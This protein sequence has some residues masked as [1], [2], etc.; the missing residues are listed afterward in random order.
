M[1]WAVRSYLPEYE[2][3][4]PVAQA[5]GVLAIAVALGVVAYGTTLIG[6]W[7]L[8]GFSDGAEKMIYSKIQWR[9]KA[10]LGGSAGNQ[11]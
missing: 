3:G 7:A 10:L 2:V 4:M 11:D 9:V 5:G 1:I 8:S 6:L